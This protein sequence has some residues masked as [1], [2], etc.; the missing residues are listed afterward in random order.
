MAIYV[1]IEQNLAKEANEGGKPHSFYRLGKDTGIPQNTLSRLRQ[2]SKGA[3]KQAKEDGKNVKPLD[4]ISFD[5][6]ERI[7]RA[8]ECDIKDILIM[9]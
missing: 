5:V 9:E 4:S 3:I 6:L 2:G 1:E 8:L 7:C